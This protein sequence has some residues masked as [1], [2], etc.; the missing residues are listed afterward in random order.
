MAEHPKK[1]KSSGMME[2]IMPESANSISEIPI[3]VYEALPVRLPP[4]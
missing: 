2:N 1:I 4:D 3:R